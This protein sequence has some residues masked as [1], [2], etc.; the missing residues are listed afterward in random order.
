MQFELI[1]S[2]PLSNEYIDSFYKQIEQQQKDAERLEELE[3]NESGIITRRKFL[4][5]SALGA[6]GLGL[7]LS[8]EKSE[9]WAIPPIVPI[10]IVPVGLLLLREWF[11]S[12]D[13]IK[14]S[15]VIENKGNQDK[16]NTMELELLSS[17]D[18]RT[19]P[20]HASYYV[21]AFK[22]NTYRIKNGPNARVKRDT[23]VYARAS[24]EHGSTTSG[25]F[26]IEA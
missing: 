12:R 16:S 21:P 8:T 11:R 2:K 5:Y 19:R 26:I 4:Q 6:V 9:A 1:D 15:I 18:I 24:N 22:R 13:P 17:V 7:G 10:L 25:S 14:G 3:Y 20:R 23:R